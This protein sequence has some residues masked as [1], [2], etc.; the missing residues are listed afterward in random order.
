[1]ATTSPWLAPPLAT[2]AALR[3]TRPS[4]MEPWAESM[5]STEQVAEVISAACRAELHVPLSLEDRWMDT[6][7]S[8]SPPSLSYVSLSL[9]GDTSDVVGNSA[10]SASI[11]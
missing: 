11:E 8:A 5:T 2:S 10:L 9:P 4:P 7:P 6:M 3:T 1:M